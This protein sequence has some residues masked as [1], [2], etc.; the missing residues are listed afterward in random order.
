MPF[1]FP[2]VGG[3]GEILQ[4]REDALGKGLCVELHTPPSIRI[5]LQ[6][7]LEDLGQKRPHDRYCRGAK[8][9]CY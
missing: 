4:P 5:I 1:V 3:I 6:S 2:E 9:D 8:R 7:L